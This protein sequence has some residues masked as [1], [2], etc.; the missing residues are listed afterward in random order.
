MIL[1][2]YCAQNDGSRVR[3]SLA[4]KLWLSVSVIR[5][6]MLS[7]TC[8]FTWTHFWFVYPIFCQFVTCAVQVT[9]HCKISHHHQA[10]IHHNKY[11][12]TL[13]VVLCSLVYNCANHCHIQ[14]CL[15]V[16]KNNWP[17]YYCAAKTTANF[18]LHF[19]I[20]CPTPTL[21]RVVD[22]GDFTNWAI[23]SPT[24]GTKSVVRDFTAHLG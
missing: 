19:S 18:V 12:C 15:K 17:N 22:T 24:P 23:E 21:G 3:G 16:C 9:N 6:L 8:L 7:R 10:Y 1:S 13:L 5:E 20:S 14:Q 2:T 11:R 4:A